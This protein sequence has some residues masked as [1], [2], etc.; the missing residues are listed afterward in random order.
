[1][2]NVNEY[3]L[4][5]TDA[6]A[7]YQKKLTAGTGIN[8]DPL[9]DTISA[10]GSG[11]STVTYTPNVTTGMILGILGINGT[12]NP[13][14]S[15]SLI[16]GQNV[17]ITQD[18]TT[19]ALTFS[20]VNTTYNDMVGADGTDPGT[21]GLAPA[22]AATD[23]TKFLKGDG[24][25][26][27]PVT[28]NPVAAATATL[29][30]LSINN[31]V[32]DL[33]GGTATYFGTTDPSN[34]LGNNGDLYFKYTSTP[35]TI[36]DEITLPTFVD[37]QSTHV[38][39]PNFEDYIDVSFGY[40]DANRN[41]GAKD[42]T[43]EDLPQNN[44]PQWSQG[45]DIYIM[46]GYYYAVASRDSTGFWIKECGNP[47]QSITVSYSGYSYNIIST[48]V[49]IEG[50]WIVFSTGGGGGSEVIANPSGTATDVLNKIEI[51]DVIYSLPSGGGGA[52]G[53]V[54]TLFENDG[55]TNPAS[56]TLDDDLTNY[57]IVLFQLGATSGDAIFTM[58]YNVA[59][60]TAG[61][62]IGAGSAS[63]IFVWY[64]YTDSTTLT[65]RVSAGNVY[66]STIVGIK[67]GGS[68]GGTGSFVGLTKAEYDALPTS[69]KE[70][71]N[72]LYLVQEGGGGTLTTPI[73]MSGGTPIREGSMNFN[74]TS[75]SVQSVWNGG[76][77]IGGQY[78]LKAVDLTDVD[79]LI[80][81]LVTTT[82]YAHN[83]S[84]VEEQTNANWHIFV[85]LS[86]SIPTS[87]ATV[88][89]F[90]LYAEYKY[91]NTTY[92]SS[93]CKLDV[94]SLTGVYYITLVSHGW[95]LVLSNLKAKQA[96]MDQIRLDQL[97]RYKK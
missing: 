32:Y 96:D 6:E 67:F 77:S 19:G 24:S 8:I 88:S 58:A 54:T 23:N 37:D 95:N 38:T 29:T 12:S 44:N 60:L 20:S 47:L 85:G 41:P 46:N 68:G 39:I 90:S 55:T 14:K 57:D 76:S 50:R 48:Y 22:P 84:N 11:G 94:S 61:D 93:E 73:D 5:Q 9:T 80:W 86:Q 26:G 42:F 45:G 13:I 75:T 36:E 40:I 74:T 65:L 18:Q 82:C 28:A 21:H 87:W 27:D 34:S 56:I 1:M 49:K 92:S 97:R 81:E 2:P 25:W 78:T 91:T 89:T 35:A 59:D 17:S 63:S 3:M 31:T 15:P 7:I 33:A 62:T 64:Y 71:T 16:A 72:K 79:E 70:D 10:T 30:K 43:I 83:N 69:E 53:S 51:D 52:S 66:M 4:K